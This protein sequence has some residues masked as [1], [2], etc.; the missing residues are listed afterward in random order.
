[1]NSTS[2]KAAVLTLSAM[3]AGAAVLGTAGASSAASAP[4][5]PTM[6]Q[7]AEATITISGFAYTISGVVTP[8]ATVTVINN[9]NEAHTVT[10]RGSG[11]SFDTGAVAGGATGTFTAP[12]TPGEYNFVCIFHG[13]MSGTLVVQEA[14]ALPP[15]TDDNDDDGAPQDGNMN[16]GQM[17]EM[18]IGGADTAAEPEE[19]GNLGF[20][21]LGGGFV[22]LAAAG[23]TYIV[24]KRSE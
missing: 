10:G 17:G 4:S 22:L 2:H 15:S 14:S 19:G 24:R 1:M 23:G 8:G 21:A 13:N 5:L 18:P 7:S 12:N 16:P 6:T 20:L 9:D 3:L 11:Q